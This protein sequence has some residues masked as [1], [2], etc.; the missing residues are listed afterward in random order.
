MATFAFTPFAENLTNAN[1]S[2]DFRG[3]LGGSPSDKPAPIKGVLGDID[4]GLVITASPVSIE[5]G[6]SIKPLI[7]K[8]MMIYIDIYSHIVVPFI[9]SSFGVVSNV[10]NLII[11]T[12]LGLKDGMSV[13]LWSLSFS[14]LTGEKQKLISRLNAASSHPQ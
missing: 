14:D 9:V 1:L 4:I 10:I 13:G 11:F 7:P 5:A 6:H 2:S 8:S 12:R 3:F